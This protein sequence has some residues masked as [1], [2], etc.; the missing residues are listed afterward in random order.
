MHLVEPGKVLGER[1][2]ERDRDIVL[3]AAGPLSVGRKTSLDCR[4]DH[5]SAAASP[6]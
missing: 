5:T 2:L 4:A 1:D 6:R 3:P